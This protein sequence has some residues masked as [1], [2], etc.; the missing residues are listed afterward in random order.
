MAEWLIEEGIAETRALCLDGERVVATRLEWPGALAAGEVADATLI[1]RAAGS[2]R[3]TVSF[4]G[5]QEA[6]IDRLP[7][8]ASEGATLRCRVTRAALAERDRRKLARATPTD[9][10]VRDAPSLRASLPGA[11]VVRRFPS[12]IWE[13][14]WLEAWSGTAAFDGGELA[15]FDTAAMT[16]ID[17]DGSGA[18]LALSRAAVPALADALHKFDM[19]GNIGIDFPTVPTKAE[20]KVVD[21]A[22]AEALGDWPH[23]RTAMNGFGFVQI[24]SRL[25]GPSLLQRIH[26]ARRAAASR[27]LLRRGEMLEGPGDLLL[28]CHPAIQSKLRDDWIDSLRRRTGRAVVIKADPAL[29]LE[30]GQAQLVQR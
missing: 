14:L 5:G 27:L 24:V 22:L 15:F 1:H 21:A 23:E 18:P 11:K 8:S 29:A 16:V 13:D 3:G 2:K 20:R 10:P 17:I 28:T 7:A 30:A 4:A 26:H 25:E 12:G 6:L 9:E 19:G